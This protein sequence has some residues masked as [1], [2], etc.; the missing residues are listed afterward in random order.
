MSTEIMTV[1]RA[2][3]APEHT[4]ACEPILITDGLMDWPAQQRWS[5]ETL[6]ALAG[7][8]IVELQASRSGVWRWNPDGSVS[9][10]KDQFSMGKMPFAAAADRIVAEEAGVPKYYVPQ[11]SIGLNFPQ[12]L[13]DLRFPSYEARVFNL[14]YTFPKFARSTTNL[15][16]GS[17]GTVTSL[18]F[19]LSNNL[20][21]QVYGSKTMTLFGPEQDAALYRH[22][23]ECK[24]PHFSFVDVDKPDYDAF[25]RFREARPL[26]VTLRPGQMLFMPAFW[27][28]HVKSESMSIS[29]NQWFHPSLHQ[30]NGPFAWSL[31]VGAFKRD[32]FADARSHLELD[33]VGLVQLALDQ[34]EMSPPLGVLL[35]SVAAGEAVGRAAPG[36]LAGGRLQRLQE[37]L[38][39]LVAIALAKDGLDVGAA[40]AG[41]LRQELAAV[42]GAHGVLPSAAAATAFPA[43]WAPSRASGVHA[44]AP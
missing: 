34:L 20:Y 17:G 43:P 35:A 5:P 1:T 38:D 7:E 21:A 11:L 24:M 33:D 41:W 12:L 14:W 16:F 2:E 18:H 37:R 10:P 4:H 32:R 15:W 19:D 22:P 26:R 8:T 40:E 13:S 3:F 42:L 23:K 6:R 39:G 36:V 9:D 31:L 30:M 25:P 28:H 29:V 27:W 44:V